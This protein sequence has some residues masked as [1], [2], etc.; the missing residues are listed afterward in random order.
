MCVCVCVCVCVCGCVCVCVCVY[1]Y[2]MDS[3]L[4]VTNVTAI[5]IKVINKCTCTHQLF[6][7]M[8]QYV[9][10]NIAQI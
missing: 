1:N 4:A 5:G 3:D 8:L 2:N 9:L 7:L 10:V 6:I